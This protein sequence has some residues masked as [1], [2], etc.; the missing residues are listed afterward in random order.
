MPRTRDEQFDERLKSVSQIDWARLAAFIDGEGTISIK[1][2]NR[3]R[4]VPSVNH[5]LEVSVANTSVK[6]MNWLKATFGGN[7]RFYQKQQLN[8]RPCM[9]WAWTEGCAEKLLLGCLPYFIIKREQAEVGLTFR[10]LKR[11]N[12]GAGRRLSQK[13]VAERSAM[14]DAM[15][16]LNTPKVQ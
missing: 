5:F 3:H 9:R 15:K 8:R 10:E 4:A 1:A 7:I 11:S 14:H 6:L 12:G 2:S 13:A 16:N